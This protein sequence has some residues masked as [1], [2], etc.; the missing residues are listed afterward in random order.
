MSEQQKTSDCEQKPEIC[1]TELDKRRD[2]KGIFL[3]IASAVAF[4]A[5]IF[6]LYTAGG[7]QLF[8]LTHRAIHLS[9]I[10]FLGYLYY[11]ATKHDKQRLP[12]YDVFLALTVV[13]LSVYLILSIDQLVYRAGE[14]I[15][16]DWIFGIVM[17]LLVLELTRRVVGSA[18]AIIAGVFLL[19]AYLGPFMPGILIHKG[20]SLERIFAYL[21][22]SLNGIFGIPLGVSAEFIFLFILFGAFLEKSGAGK[23]FIDLAYALT[24]WSRGGPAKASVIASGLLGSISG[25]SVANAV[26]SGAFTIP[27][28]KKVKYSS[29]FSAGVEAAA[30]TGG[31]I[32]PPIMGA[33]AFI[34]AEFLG[35][36]FVDIAIAALVPAVLYF[37]SLIMMTHFRAGRLGLKPIDKD[38]IPSFW[39]TFIGKIHLMFPLVILIIMIFMGFSPQRAVFSAILAMILIMLLESVYIRLIKAE[40]RSLADLKNL[41]LQTGKSIYEA[42]LEG[43]KKAIQ[44]AVACACAGIIVGIVTMTGLGLKLA[45]YIEIFS[46]G[47]LLY[48]LLLTMFASLILGIGLPTT[49]KYIVLATLVAPALMRLDV[50]SAIG[51]HLFILYFAIYADITP[52]VSL[53][54]YATAGLAGAEPLQASIEAF[55]LGLSGYL[56]PF[57][58]IY[59]PTLILMGEPFYIILALITATVGIIALSAAIQGFLV[60]TLGIM[61]RLLFGGAA[62]FNIYPGIT[63]DAVGIGV[64]AIAFFIHWNIN[65]GRSEESA[66][67]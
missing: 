54:A 27:L 48:G 63:S 30:S 33:A 2:L 40:K 18:L 32:M 14:P 31:Q 60:H 55:K 53:T 58:F 26:T 5:A 43:T 21:Y 12:V 39:P 64:L 7:G 36:P 37:V 19:Y 52:P 46:Q 6:H 49:A 10:G 16:R 8:A 28:M 61:E 1:L 62:L 67:A 42:F 23:Y 22:M 9:F 38:E 3:V 34:M 11:P 57:I 65:K 45:G 4:A 20:Y 59:N 24:G 41:L 47:V 15:L 35:V 17:V 13:G 56:I 44:V 29:S 66:T 51:A 50:S 25:S